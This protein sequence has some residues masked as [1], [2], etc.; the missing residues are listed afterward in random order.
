MGEGGGNAESRDPVEAAGDIAADADVSLHRESHGP[1]TGSLDSA[2]LPPSPAKG[3]PLG[4][5]AISTRAYAAKLS[6]H[7]QCA[8]AFGF[9]TL[10]P[11]F[12]RSSL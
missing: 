6:P 1:S 10:N 2:P 9:V 8:S 12:C 5:T 7:E 11:P 3:A 4:M